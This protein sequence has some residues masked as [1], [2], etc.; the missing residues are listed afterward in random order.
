MCPVYTFGVNEC[1]EKYQEGQDATK[2]R[3]EQQQ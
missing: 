1:T 3:K 2:C